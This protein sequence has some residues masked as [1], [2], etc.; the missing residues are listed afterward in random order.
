MSPEEWFQR[1]QTGPNRYQ[2]YIPINFDMFLALGALVGD[3]EDLP[4]QRAS[5][6]G[7][8]M[9]VLLICWY[10]TEGGFVGTSRQTGL[11]TW[12]AG[13]FVSGKFCPASP[14]VA[15]GWL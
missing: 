1:N 3:P 7:A 15:R 14:A 12:Q 5:S 2:A 6:S 11:P 4:A 13:G 8:L 9:S 10:D